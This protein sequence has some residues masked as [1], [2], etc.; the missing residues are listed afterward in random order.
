MKIHSLLLAAFVMM[1]G[2]FAHA[3]TEVANRD[4]LRQKFGLDAY[5]P[6]A[7]LDTMKIAILDNGFQGYE[8]GKGLLPESTELIEGTHNP[9]AATNHGLGMAQIIWAMT[10]QNAAGPKFYLVNTNGFSNLKT[11]VD[12]VIAQKVDIVLY[13]QVWSFGDNFD[14]KGFINALVNKATAAGVLWINAAGN[15]GGMVYNGKVTQLE[16]TTDHFMNYKNGQNYLAFE[17]KLDENAVTITLTWTD[18]Q[19]TE[20]YNSVKDLDLFV[21]DDKDN[22][23]G[24]STLIQKGQAP[25]EDGKPSQL[26]SYARETVSLASLDRGNYKIKVLD[27]SNN[28][29]STDQFRVLIEVTRPGTV[30][31]TDH[32]SGYEV[33]PPADNASVFTVGEQ[34]ELSSVGPTVDGR[35]KPDTTIDDATVDFTNGDETRGSSNAAAIITGI[36]AEMKAMNSNIDFKALSNYASQLGGNA[37]DLRPVAVPVNPKIVSWIP[38][39]G[40]IMFAPNNHLVITTPVDPLQLPLFKNQNA[41]RKNPTD[42][43]VL[44]VLDNTWHGFP[45]SQE[46]LIAAPYVEFRMVQRGSW[47]TPSPNAPVFSK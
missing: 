14:G 3:A 39:G 24:S 31:F 11:A 21:Y 40:R 30:V 9:Q 13:S 6:G 16:N 42:V 2:S 4:Q 17:N 15:F 36:V 18:F 32:T 29:V 20:T 8:P 44:S 34:T 23:V 28:F 46:P 10:G 33:M 26:S 5:S 1:S 38:Q 19:E 25:A 27:K 45:A 43:L 47:V 7:A 12:F 41:Y 35:N 22:L 37:A